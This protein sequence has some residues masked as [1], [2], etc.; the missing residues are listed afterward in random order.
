M[1]L[2]TCLFLAASLAATA[3]AQTE[4]VSNDYFPA[5]QEFQDL[6]KIIS[7]ETLEDPDRLSQIENGRLF[8]DVGFVKYA[9]RVY[10]VNNGGRLS[11]EVVTLLDFRAAYSLL[12]LLRKSPIQD[13]PP[14]NVFAETADGIML[15]QRREW[16]NVRGQ[17]VSTDLIKRIA[18]SI[19]HKI[20][21]DRKPKSPSLISH[22]PKLGFDSSTLRYFPDE[23]SYQTYS[24]GIPEILK[25]DSDRE[26]AQARYAIGDRS[27]TVF[28][29]D[30]PT[31]QIA[32]DYFSRLSISKS[33]EKSA[34]RIYAK[35]AGPIVAILEGAFDPEG[36]DRILS[37]LKFTYSVYWDRE[38]NNRDKIIWG[39]PAGILRTVVKSL[40]F[41]A[42]MC[43]VSIAAG[44][45]F[46]YF[47][48]RLRERSH[49]DSQDNH[50][51]DDFTS[52][53]LQ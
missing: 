40:F 7:K 28:L 42:F 34:G 20:G 12:S 47:R 2:F 46:G 51:Q 15:A 11:I 23:K 31:S 1:R 21:P 19:S 6:Q 17:D 8:S 50:E 32:E 13:G 38:K 24:G 22:F 45:C 3:I 44:I 26:I 14:G 27:G 30:F 53:R 41:V 16:V 9:R 43:L 33:T 10:S 4:P 49:K 48:F 5:N 25:S 36:A 52:L 29:L 35:R 39:V 37:S 18:D